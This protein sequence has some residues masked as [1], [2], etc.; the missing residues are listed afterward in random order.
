M[1]GNSSTFSAGQ[2]AAAPTE[3][4]SNNQHRQQST[5]PKWSSPPTQQPDKSLIGAPSQVL[6]ANQMPATKMGGANMM[7]ANTPVNAQLQAM[8][9]VCVLF[10]YYV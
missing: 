6:A 5:Q 8:P 9:K 2:P 3:F 10:Q 7:A 1:S 4:M